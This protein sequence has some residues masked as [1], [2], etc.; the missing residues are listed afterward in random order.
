MAIEDFNLPPHGQIPGYTGHIPAMRTHALGH[1]YTHQTAIAALAAQKLKAGETPNGMDELVENRPQGRNAFH[2]QTA[3]RGATVKA[4][5]NELYVNP[6]DY[7][8]PTQAT[9]SM[10][11]LSFAERKFVGRKV[12]EEV[13]PDEDLVAKDKIPGYTG[14]MHAKQHVYGT[15]FGKT[16]VGLDRSF[17]D[18]LNSSTKLLTYGPN[19]PQGDVL[20]G[21]EGRIPGYTGHIASKERHIYGH[22]YG[23]ATRLAKGAVAVQQ[24][25]GSASAQPQLVDRRPHS[26]ADLYTQL[27]DKDAPE[28]AELRDRSSVVPLHL[29]VSVDKFKCARAKMDRTKAFEALEKPEYCLPGYTGHL[30]GDQHVYGQTYGRATNGALLERGTARFVSD[31]LLK[32]EDARPQRMGGTSVKF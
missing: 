12:P 8:L 1:T 14:H 18:T 6:L 11:G 30:H 29:K 24:A 20:Q 25:G 28:T 23:N 9:A 13:I 3:K 10:P 26:K 2:A 16:V 21:H 31:D 17:A 32:Y 7:T 15:S 19:R 5:S 4:K 27:P 22:T